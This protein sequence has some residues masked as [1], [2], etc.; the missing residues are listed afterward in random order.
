M[1]EQK[2]Q[3]RII[4][5]RTFLKGM[6]WTPWIFLSSGIHDPSLRPLFESSRPPHLSSTHFADIRFTPRYP[7]KSPL[8]D[9]LRLV[10][11]G[12]DEYLTE[13]Y[14]AE[15]ARMLAEWGAKLKVAPPAVDHLTKFL[16]PG[17]QSIQWS[18]PE[19]RS[20]RSDY[21]LEVL[22]RHF[23]GKGFSTREQF[24][25]QIKSYF[26]DMGQIETA[27]FEV[28]KIEET[29]GPQ[30]TVRT[31]VRYNLVSS[32]GNGAR[33]QRVGSWQMQWEQSQSTGW[34]ATSWEFIDE[35][36][37]RARGSVF[38]DITS[39]V[40]GQTDSYKS[41]MLRGSGYWRSVLDGACGIDVYGN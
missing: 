12:S 16:R 35:T 11:P 3:Q 25:Q 34:Q 29:P 38:V 15:I 33:E 31:Q 17:L 2:D 6:R 39:R 27:E 1:A 30:P 32:R 4:S 5:R 8:D 23:T 19:A 10:A 24:L 40:I 7:I 20:V 18:R 41:Q 28:V 26:A 14:A 13:K 21:G 9:L 37:S 22:R 36:L